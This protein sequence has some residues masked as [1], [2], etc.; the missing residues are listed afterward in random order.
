MPKTAVRLTALC[1]HAVAGLF[2]TSASASAAVVYD[3]IPTPL[4]A[5][6]PSQP[7]QA[8]QTGQYGG[9]V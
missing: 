9:Q 2:A 6:L 5:N 1:V 8:Q 4:P 3:N 7:F